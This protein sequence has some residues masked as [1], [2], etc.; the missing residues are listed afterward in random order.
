MHV[1]PGV[2]QC[3]IEK[4]KVKSKKFKP[5]A[6]ASEPVSLKPLTWKLSIPESE[7]CEE[8]VGSGRVATGQHVV[9]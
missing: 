5:Q 1:H 7:A 9:I 4:S 8:P 6:I 2:S 3:L